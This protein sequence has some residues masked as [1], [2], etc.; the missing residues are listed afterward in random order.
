MLVVAEDVI[1]RADD[2]SAAVRL[3]EALTAPGRKGTAQPASAQANALL[4]RALTAYTEPHAIANVA[5]LIRKRSADDHARAENA[6]RVEIAALLTEADKAIEPLSILFHLGEAASTARRLGISD[7]E[8]QAV[9]RL[10]SAP[11]VR[12]RTIEAEINLPPLFVNTFMRPF[13]YAKGWREALSVWF[14]TEAPSGNHASN[15]ATARKALNETVFRRVA[16]VT[17]YGHHNLP[18]KVISSDDDAYTHELARIEQYAMDCY[19]G[20]LANALDLTRARFSIPTQADLE[21]FILGSGTHPALARRLAQAL[22]LYWV[23]EYAACVHLAAPKVEAAARALLLELNE[24]V[25][26]TAVGDAAGQFP[27]LG[28]FLDHLVNNG[29]DPDWERFLRTF[30]LSEGRNVRNFVAHG[31]MDDPDRHTAAL[32]LRACAVMALITSEAT[33]QR[34]SADVRAALAKP[35]HGKPRRSSWQRVM[36]AARAAYLELRR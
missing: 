16:R 28:V 4:D 8:Q 2:S 12:W 9:A 30:L 26:R 6:S 11:P 23:G 22:R 15:E 19:G 5:K 20:L 25:Y 34:D 29:F 1:T 32:T 36:D 33:A 18:K 35:L 24:P 13:R 3:L 10:Q 17:I 27:G 21:T 14:A 31:F 7:L